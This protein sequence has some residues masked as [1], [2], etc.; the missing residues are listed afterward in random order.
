MPLS[1]RMFREMCAIL[2]P[3]SVAISLVANDLGPV[4]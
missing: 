3:V 4:L 1:A 2:I